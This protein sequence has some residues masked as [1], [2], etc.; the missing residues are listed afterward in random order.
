MKTTKVVCDVCNK[1]IKIYLERTDSLTYPVIID[2][3]TQCTRIDMCD[4]CKARL[5]MSLGKED[6]VVIKWL[7]IQ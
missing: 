3:N 4:N 2:S 7:N 1:E 5:L 6:K